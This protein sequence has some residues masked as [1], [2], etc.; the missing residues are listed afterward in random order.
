MADGFALALQVGLRAALAA[1]AG[2]TALVAGRIYDEPPSDVVFPYLRF[3]DISPDAFDT[4]SK[5]G[6]LVEVGLVAHSQSAS[7]RVEAAQIIE[8]AKNALHRQESSVTVPGFTLVE[9]IFQTHVTRR[10][11]EGRGYTA[12]LALRAML[13]SA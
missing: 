11:P 6:A 3:G 7:G 1:D 10:D 4:D 9:L 5:E 13:E 2:V 8:A 12:T